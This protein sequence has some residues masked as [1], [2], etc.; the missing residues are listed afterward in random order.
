MAE[1]SRNRNLRT[2]LILGTVALAFF[3]G[4]I[5]KYLLLK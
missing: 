5:I 2:G 4:V 1:P 3:F